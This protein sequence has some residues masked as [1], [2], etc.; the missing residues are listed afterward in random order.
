LQART[1]VFVFEADVEFGKPQRWHAFGSAMVVRYSTILPDMEDWRAAYY[2][3]RRARSTKPFVENDTRARLALPAAEIFVALFLFRSLFGPLLCQCTVRSALQLVGRE[4]DATAIVIDEAGLG[5]AN[6]SLKARTSG[7]AQTGT[8][9]LRV[10]SASPFGRL[11]RSDCGLHHLGRSEV[12]PG[13]RIRAR[14]S[15]DVC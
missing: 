11:L 7:S 15:Q 9:S 5:Y 2:E 1:P 14:P 4:H 6:E 13:A 8:G 12:G 10:V 3:A